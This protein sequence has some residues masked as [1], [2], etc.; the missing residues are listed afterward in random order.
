[1]ELYNY[2][3]FDKEL[4][5]NTGVYKIWHN[6]YPNK[7]YIGSAACIN[8]NNKKE[9]GFQRRLKRHLS[10]L[11]N[12]KH[13]NK[14]LQ[15]I[16]NKYSIEELCFDIIEICDI[17][18]CIE[19]EQYWTDYYK[20]YQTGYNLRKKAENNLGLK[21]SEETKQKIRLGN[22]NKIVSEESKK[23]M[24]ESSKGQIITEATKIKLRN[25]CKHKK[26]I[27]VYTID[28]YYNEFES[29]VLCSKHFS[30]SKKSMSDYARLGKLYKYKYILSF[31]PLTQE[32][33]NKKFEY[34]KQYNIQKNKNMILGKIYKKT[35]C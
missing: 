34:Y 32:E 33:I 18:K 31:V 30:F 8:S 12:N 11:K 6:K 1:M 21:H 17:D 7:F 23:K 26:K 2:I 15:N 27:Y 29:G 19:R 16:I 5:Q 9:I 25:N 4:L 20:S 10:E 24:S 22:L 3:K 28:G 13:K 35:S 14:Y